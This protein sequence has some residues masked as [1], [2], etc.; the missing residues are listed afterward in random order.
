M[1]AF[2]VRAATTPY[3]VEKG[4]TRLW[5]KPETMCLMVASGMTI[6]MAKPATT[7][8]K[9][10]KAMMSYMAVIIMIA[11]MMEMTPLTVA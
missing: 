7:S 4:T 2:M 1:T 3:R 11:V 10:A 5:A 6:S 9:V 8:Y